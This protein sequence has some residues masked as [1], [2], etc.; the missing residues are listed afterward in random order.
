MPPVLFKLSVSQRMLASSES[1]TTRKPIICRGRREFS[2]MAFSFVSP[3]VSGYVRI[4]QKHAVSL[5]LSP[6]IWLDIPRKVMFA[7][8]MAPQKQTYNLEIGTG[9]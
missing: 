1:V 8:I 5:S 2:Y 9:F 6:L 7:G 3:I 4:Q